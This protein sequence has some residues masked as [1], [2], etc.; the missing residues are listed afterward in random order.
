MT[1]PATGVSN[2]AV[3][4]LRDGLRYCL[5]VFLAVRIG[6]AMVSVV[7]PTLIEPRPADDRPAVAGWPI[8]PV[9][10]G[11][12]NVITATERQDAA[13]FLSIATD[14]YGPDD[15]SAA[16]F[17][18]YPLCVRVV[19][20]LPGI[21]PL[22]AALLVSNAAFAGALIMLY[23]LTRL[24]FG[25][26][27][28]ARRSVLFFAIFPTAFFF[29]APYTESL[30]LLCSISAFWFARRN[31]WGWAAVA[32][33]G[34]ALTRSVGILLVPALAVEALAQ[35]RTL[36]RP[37][38]PRLA[39]AVSALVGPLL[40]GAFWLARD[41]LWAPVRAQETW[42]RDLTWPWVTIADALSFALRLGS[43]WMVDLLIV[44]VVAIAV[45]AGIPR[46]RRCYSTYAALSLLLP[47][48]VPW[49]SRPLLSMP[50]FVAVL[51][52]V[53]WVFAWAVERWRVPEAL[54]VAVS[55]GSY[56]VLA[57]LF[58][59]WWHIF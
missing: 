54:I 29:M 49:P 52:P 17:P 30:F 50:R 22:G 9:T 3:P 28:T 57:I 41:D 15:G 5:L 31:R 19:S 56:V 16:F 6:L 45:V 14:G 40:Y 34:A 11:L 20:W 33:I 42:A 53:S 27:T 47:L 43:Y 48:C 46:L 21:G 55:S 25:S 36:G 12:H 26:V 44:G 10:P 35:W 58:I 13:W 38:A 4:R 7:G 2:V 32:G 59:N 37:L 39:S 51:F 24:E 18:L 8:G 23:G 1:E